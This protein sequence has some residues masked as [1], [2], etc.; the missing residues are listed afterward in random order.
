[1]FSND[2]WDYVDK[3]PDMPSR[4]DRDRP[5][6]QGDKK[7]IQLWDYFFR[8]NPNDLCMGERDEVASL[9]DQISRATQERDDKIAGYEREIAD[10]ERRIAQL[11]RKRR[12]RGFIWWGLAILVAIGGAIIETNTS[13]YGDYSGVSLAA[14]APFVLFGLIAFLRIPGAGRDEKK[15]IEEL[16]EQIEQAREDFEKKKKGFEKRIEELEAHIKMIVGQLPTPPADEQVLKWLQEDL[17]ALR[18]HSVEATGLGTRLVDIRFE[19]EDGSVSTADNP[20]VILGPGELQDPDSMPHAFE[21]SEDK[22]RHLRARRE[23]STDGRGFEVLYGIYYLEYVLVADDMLATCGFFYDF[24]TGDTAAEC[25]TE[26]YYTDVVAIAMIREDRKIKVSDNQGGTQE[27]WVYDAPTFRLSL[28]SSEKREVTFVNDQYFE[29]IAAKHAKVGQALEG[30]GGEKQRI[31]SVIEAEQ[32]ADNAV[33]ALRS[34]L[35]RHKGTAA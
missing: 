2:V 15:E 35:R 33:K 25:V 4:A 19:G 5:R 9:H 32:V 14:A 29:K 16:R 18:T 27:V 6:N 7:R 1:M 31:R 12:R 23:V 26:Q 10:K 34:F 28:A 24:I 11:K 21:A 20:I 3:L 8:P 22:D 30:D 17:A 13:Y